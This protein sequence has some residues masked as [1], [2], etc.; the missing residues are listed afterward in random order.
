MIFHQT[1]DLNMKIR[2]CLIIN[3]LQIHEKYQN[4]PSNTQIN[5]KIHFKIHEK[6][7]ISPPNFINKL[8]N[9]PS[10]IIQ[11]HHKL[12]KNIKIHHQIH[13]KHQ[14]SPTNQQKNIKIHH[15]IHEKHQ[16]SK[17]IH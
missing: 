14:N 9:L 1:I 3:D 16:N 15:Q 11:I 12:S 4:S 8:Q 17:Q 10:K 7:Q 2:Y 13:E 5:F 6:H